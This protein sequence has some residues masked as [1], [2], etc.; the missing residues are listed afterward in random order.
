MR[1]LVL[2]AALILPTIGAHGQPPASRAV[3]GAPG[4]AAPCADPSM[5]HQARPDRS[6]KLHKLGELPPANLYLSVY[7][8]VDGCQVPVIAG[9]GIGSTGQRR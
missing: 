5:V 1:L 4:T 8:L 3:A 7:R 2:A 9:Y 6:A